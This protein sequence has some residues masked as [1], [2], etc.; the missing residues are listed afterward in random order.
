MKDESTREFV[1]NF[2]FDRRCTAGHAGDADGGSSAPGTGAPYAAPADY[3]CGDAPGAGTSYAAPADYACGDAPGAGAPYAAPAEKVCGEQ[4]FCRA[5]SEAEHLSQVGCASADPVHAASE[6]AEGSSCGEGKRAFRR[7]PTAPG[8]PP[9]PTDE[10][11][12]GSRPISWVAPCCVRN[13]PVGPALADLDFSRGVE[14]GIRGQRRHDCASSFSSTFPP[15]SIAVHSGPAAFPSAGAAGLGPSGSNGKRGACGRHSDRHVTSGAFAFSDSNHRCPA[16]PGAADVDSS[17]NNLA[18]GVC[19]CNGGRCGGTA[20]SAASAASASSATNAVHRLYPSG[21]GCQPFS[22]CILPAAA[23]S[24]SASCFGFGFR[25]FAGDVRRPERRPERTFG[26]HPV[27][28]DRRPQACRCRSAGCV[29]P[30]HP[31][32]ASVVE[33][34]ERSSGKH[35]ICRDRRPQALSGSGGSPAHSDLASALASALAARS[36]AVTGDSSGERRRAGRRNEDFDLPSPPPH[37]F[38]RARV[39]FFFPFIAYDSFPPRQM[40]TTT[41]TT[42]SGTEAEK[43][44]RQRKEKK[45]TSPFSSARR[46]FFLFC[47]RFAPPFFWFCEFVTPACFHIYLRPA[48][49]CLVVHLLR[50]FCVLSSF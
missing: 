39:F 24:A 11:G 19:G 41:T 44:K 46:I 33:R 16:D 37:F 35:S 17:G 6:C 30:G 26:K 3:A 4:Y 1:V 8:L 48:L 31:E 36:K 47:A 32:H 23:S 12:F 29:F 49:F 42:R 38:G 10:L 27:C 18:I 50:P 25:G 15:S 40:K 7:P 28:R 22:S 9:D 20:A 43:K 5:R 45:T 21:S 13:S 34:P 14:S 2:H